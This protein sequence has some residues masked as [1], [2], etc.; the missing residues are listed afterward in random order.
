MTALVDY[1]RPEDA[2][3][4]SPRRNMVLVK[5]LKVEKASLIVMPNNVERPGIQKWEVVSAG[6]GI[7]TAQGFVAT[8]TKPG[9]IVILGGFPEGALKFMED[10]G[11][12]DYAVISEVDIV[13]DYFEVKE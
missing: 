6:K 1:K 7:Q 12:K 9:E 8:D 3:P 13:A 5:K 10:L 4:F 11:F 2:P